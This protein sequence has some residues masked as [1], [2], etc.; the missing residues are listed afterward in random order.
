MY[1]VYKLFSAKLKT[2]KHERLN[3]HQNSLYSYVDLMDGYRCLLEIK[4]HRETAKKKGD[5]EV[6]PTGL[7]PSRKLT[8]ISAQSRK[9]RGPQHHVK[10]AVFDVAFKYHH[11]VGLF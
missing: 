7:I 10:V 9:G 6:V 8:A 3:I 11:G 1:V 2:S 4:T 5:R